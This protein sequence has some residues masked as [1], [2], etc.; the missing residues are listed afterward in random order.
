[1]VVR[2]LLQLLE[3]RVTLQPFENLLGFA[4]EAGLRTNVSLVTVDERLTNPRP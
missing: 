4:F 1:M 3:I 2:K